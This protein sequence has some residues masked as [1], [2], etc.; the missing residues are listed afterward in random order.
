MF[1]D[2]RLTQNKV[3]SILL[4]QNEGRKKKAAVSKISIKEDIL[5]DLFPGERK[6][7][8]EVEVESAVL[9]KKK[10]LPMLLSKYDIDFRDDDE[11]EAMLIEALD[12]YFKDSAPK[13]KTIERN[14][15]TSVDL[16][17]GEEN[18]VEEHL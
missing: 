2:D 6:K 4:G 8:I 5:S 13:Y 10:T 12:T 3:Q 14:I 17:D 15:S 1:D 18:E 11:L 9:F 16:T 7:N